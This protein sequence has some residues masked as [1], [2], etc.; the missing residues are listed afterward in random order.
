M[1]LS[2]RT[3]LQVI[4]LLPFAFVTAQAS[5]KD[6]V[7]AGDYYIEGVR[8]FCA[9][10]YDKAGELLSRCVWLNPYNDAAWYYMSM[11]Q[12]GDNHTDQ[13]L[14]Y[15]DKAI[16]LSPDN[17]WYRLTKARLYSGMGESERAIELYNALIEENPEKS[18]YYYELTD[19]LMRNSKLDEALETLDR[20]DELRGVSE[21]TGNARYEILMAQSRYD[22]ALMQAL[23]LNEDFPSPRTALI[24]GDL[25]KTKYDDSTSL[26]YYNKA[27]SMEP[28]YTPA[29]FGMAE[30]YRVKRDFYNFFNSINPFLADPQI[31][32]QMKT[33]YM[34]EVIFPSGMVQIFRPQVD[35]M[36]ASTLNAHP[37]DTSVL[38]M[39]GMYFIAIDSTDKG[40]D[41]LY[42]NMELHPNVESVRMAYMGQLY[43]MQDWD[44]LITVAEETLRIFPEHFTLRELIAIAYWQKGDIKAAIDSYRQILKAAPDD[45]PILINCYGS[46]GD[47]YYELGNRSKS[48]SCYEKGLRI[49]DNYSPILNNYAYYLSEEG[50]HL[51]KA[52]EMSRK[53]VLNEPENPTYLDTYGWLLY[54]TGDY[55]EARKYLEKAKIYGGDESAVILDHYAETLFALKEYNLAF[56][57]WG[58]ADRLDP[59]MGLSVKIKERREQIKKK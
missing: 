41:I 17:Q 44:A 8:E 19:L 21:V 31:N 49:N 12:I 46:L 58:N 57:Y 11:I 56:L 24:L 47:M 30:I 20:I 50:R 55:Q 22:E 38:T 16:S 3:I 7:S 10:E 39:A 9:G 25:Y 26:Y 51:K 35:T 13:A 42:R 54:L 6:S 29:Y 28:D 4:L 43:Y 59:D 37:A 48:Y 36:V 1:N 45:H 14:D 53:T 15:L 18:N 32:P 40:M 34:E 2:V 52:L 33:S 5:D 27:V 23:K